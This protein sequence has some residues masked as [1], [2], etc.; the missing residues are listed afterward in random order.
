QVVSKE[1]NDVRIIASGDGIPKDIGTIVIIGGDE[2]TDFDIFGLDQ[3]FM[4]G[5]KAFIVQNGIDVTIS[6]YGIYA[7]PKDNKLINLLTFYGI[8]INKDLV[9]DNDSYTPL[10]QRNGIFVQQN[11]YP[12]WPKIKANNFN[13]ESPVVNEME[14]LNMFWPSSITIDEKIKNNAKVLFKT[15]KESWVQ[16]NDYKL[17]IETYKYPVQEGVKEYDLACS[18]EGELTSFFKGQNIPKNEKNPDSVYDSEKLDAGKTK[19]VVIANEFFLDSNFAGNEELLLLMNGIDS[20][21]KDASLIQIRNKG[22]FSKPLYK[23]KNQFQLNTYKNIIIGFTTYFI[24]L[25][26]II[27]AIVLN[28]RRKFI[29]KKVKDLFVKSSN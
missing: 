20:L 24:P 28:F 3:F 12:I 5:G 1:Y 13:K 17:D 26:F 21:S 23:A 29:N 14:T 18:F 22:K 15:T 11:R 8:T 25:L 9:G 2:L 19:I 10:P 6:Q 4:N 7:T 27:L 16:K